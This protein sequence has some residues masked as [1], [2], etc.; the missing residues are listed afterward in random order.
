MI[1][2]VTTAAV[3]S[4]L[5]ERYAEGSTYEALLSGLRD[6]GSLVAS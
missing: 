2:N 1:T 4:G 6:Q 3:R 5:G